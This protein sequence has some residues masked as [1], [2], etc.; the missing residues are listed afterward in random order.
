MKKQKQKKPVYKRA[1]FWILAVIVLGG[2]FS[3]V[4]SNKDK[5]V[6]SP[7]SDV[8]I[9]TMPEELSEPEAT[10]APTPAP[11]PKP[12]PVSTPKPTPAPTPEPTPAPTPEPTPAPTPEPPP[13]QLIHGVSADTIVYVS[14][15]SKTIH[16]V[17]DCSGMKN[18]REMTI[19]EADAKGY[20]YCPNCW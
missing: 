20:K 3:G 15:S 12:T 11:T 19:A 5:P 1:W 4:A 2:I 9:R 13:A 8:S 14:N 16:S 18:Y 7:A 10:P 17:H 6:E